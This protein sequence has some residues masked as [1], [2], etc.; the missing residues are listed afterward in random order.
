MIL[1]IA[2]TLKGTLKIGLDVIS[3][4]TRLV[5]LPWKINKLRNYYFLWNLAY[6]LVYGFAK[7]D[8]HKFVLLIK[9]NLIFYGGCKY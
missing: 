4:S 9:I 3:E 7:Y 6:H 2:F 8:S 5:V 1:F